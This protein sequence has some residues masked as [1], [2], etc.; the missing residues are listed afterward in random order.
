MLFAFLLGGIAGAGKFEKFVGEV[1]VRIGHGGERGGEG[2]NEGKAA[3]WLGWILPWECPCISQNLM[4][5]VKDYKPFV[6]FCSS[7]TKGYKV[8]KYPVVGDN[9][10]EHIHSSSP[11]PRISRPGASVSGYAVGFG[12][13]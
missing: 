5:S 4:T 2:L 13:F 12:C 3:S 9:F 10:P 6:I 1:A 7:H 8:V 11:N